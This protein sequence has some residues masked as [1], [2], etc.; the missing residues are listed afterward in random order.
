VVNVLLL[1]KPKVAVSSLSVF[2]L[3]FKIPLMKTTCWVLKYWRGVTPCIALKLLFKVEMEMLQCLAKVS[4]PGN[5]P[6]TFL[7][8]ISAAF[9]IG[10]ST[11]IFMISFA[12][13]SLDSLK[14]KPPIEKNRCR[15]MVESDV[16][17][18]HILADLTVWIVLVFL[19]LPLYD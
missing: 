9:S 3:P 5:L 2:S 16:S 19:H 7:S 12:P 8:R 10:F 4:K 17:P 15:L 14:K 11:S 13:C 1:V 18:F 6:P